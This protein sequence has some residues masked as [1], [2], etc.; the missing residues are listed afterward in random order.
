MNEGA[1]YVVFCQE[2]KHLERYRNEFRDW[3]YSCNHESCFE[4][5][6]HPLCSFTNRIANYDMKNEKNQCPDFQKGKPFTRSL[7]KFWRRK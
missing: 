5:E 1:K 3:C 2:C 6:L 4:D 7:W